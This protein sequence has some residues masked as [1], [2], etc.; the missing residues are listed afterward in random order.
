[1]I[2]TAARDRIFKG[3]LLA[4]AGRHHTDLRGNVLLA[5]QRS[6]AGVRHFA[7]AAH[8]LVGLEPRKTGLPKATGRCPFIA[9]TVLTSRWPCCSA[10][11]VAAGRPFHRRIFPGPADRENNR[12]GD[13]PAGRAS[14]RSS[15]GCGDLRDPAGDRPTWDC[16]RRDSASLTASVVLAIMVIPYAASLS[17][18]FIS[19]VSRELKE[20]AYS[21]GGRGST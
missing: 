17:S 1:M 21:L 6:G 15:T 8:R 18:E 2:R 9:G 4:A 14:R 13:R 20:G 12:Y 5:D 10:F 3:L 19:M 7:F 11:R 16:R